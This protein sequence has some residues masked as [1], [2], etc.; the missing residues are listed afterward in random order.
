VKDF[1]AFSDRLSLLEWTPAG[2]LDPRILDLVE[3]LGREPELIGNVVRSWTTANLDERQLSCHETKTHYKWFI[4]YNSKLRYKVWLH[5]Y[6]SLAEREAGHAEVPH[7]HRYSL[8]SL[9]IRGGFTHHRYKQ[10]DDGLLELAHERDSYTQG[11]TYLVDWHQVH[12]LSEIKNHTVTLVVESPIA[13]NF[14][15]AFYAQSGEPSMF[16][17]FIW[18]RSQLFAELSST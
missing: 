6:K 5:Q 14:S 18:L 3:E 1:R 7:N 9:I 17:D 8:A 2:Y 15:E 11:D 4:Y 13:R 16:Y 12:R 10:T